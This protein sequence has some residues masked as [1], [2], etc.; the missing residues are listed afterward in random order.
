[1]STKSKETNRRKTGQGIKVLFGHTLREVLDQQGKSWRSVA[2]KIGMH[3][4][5]LTRW[6]AGD[7][8][9]IYEDQLG[10]IIPEATSVPE[11]QLRLVCAYLTDKI[12]SQWRGVVRVGRAD[13]MLAPLRDGAINE[14]PERMRVIAEACTRD[15]A[16]AKAVDALEAW[17]VRVNHLAQQGSQAKPKKS[18]RVK[19]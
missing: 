12:P 8:S 18:S 14:M 3:E 2:L 9:D 1:M 15:P 16:I 10:A 7:W 11:I 13:E 17:S 6:K 4:Q 19:K 5:M